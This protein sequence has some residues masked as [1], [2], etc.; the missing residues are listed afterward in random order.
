METSRHRPLSGASSSSPRHYARGASELRMSRVSWNFGGVPVIIRWLRRCQRVTGGTDR[1]G[2]ALQCVAQ[3]SQVH[4]PVDP[5]DLL[6]GLDHPGGAPAQRHRAVTPVLD[7]ARVHA[8]D[9]DHGL[10]A[11]VERKVRAEV[12]PAGRTPWDAPGSAES[13]PWKLGHDPTPC[14]QQSAFPLDVLLRRH[15][16]RA[17]P[18][19]NS[20][21]VGRSGSRHL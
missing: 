8:A 13:G 21:A 4:A 17:G 2:D 14:W 10:H 7:V 6:A 18:A 9:R 20:S 19:A 12:T 15:R 1:L 16:V 5:A 3:R 11:L